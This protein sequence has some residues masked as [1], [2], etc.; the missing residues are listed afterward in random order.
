MK[1]IIF[2]S[3]A[4]LLLFGCASKNEL[5]V[6][7]D[8]DNKISKLKSYELE[9]EL[10]IY[11]NEE[12][13]KYDV[14]VNYLNNYY[15]VKMTNKD[16]NHEQIILKG[17]DGLYVITPSLNKSFKFDSNWPDNSSQTY[18]LSSVLNDIRNGS[19]KIEKTNDGYTIETKVNYP[20]N[21]SLVYQKIVLDNKSNLKEIKVY[22]TNDIVKI[23][24]IISKLSFKSSLN[25]KD[26]S[27]DKYIV[28]EECKENCDKEKTTSNIVN[29][30]YPLFVPANTYLSSSEIVSDTENSR[31]I[32]TFS[33]EKNYVLV[34]EMASAYIEHEIIPVYGEPVMLNDTIA[35]M[36]SNSLNWT[37]NGINYYLASD[38]LSIS[39]M[40]SI[41]QSLNNA[42]NVAYIK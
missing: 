8:F 10:S 9:G 5:N 13:F 25:E 36:S 21:S 29:A 4:L 28:N 26:F 6:L 2:L 27:L 11:D 33:G 34:E 31:A 12:N 35:A 3:S 24:L 22:D 14:S 39:E 18:I 19:A 20:N 16:N 30:I 38:D 41:A 17:D 23:D 1:K 40:V 32:I 15:L 37:S 42:Q 7:N